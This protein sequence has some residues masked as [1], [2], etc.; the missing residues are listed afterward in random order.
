MVRAT[1][2]THTHTQA[3][4]AI[5][6]AWRRDPGLAKARRLPSGVWGKRR[7]LAQEP[8]RCILAQEPRVAGNTRANMQEV[9]HAREYAGGATWNAREASA[10]WLCCDALREASGTPGAVQPRADSDRRWRREVIPGIGCNRRHRMYSNRR[11]L[12]PACEC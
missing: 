11:R 5:K 1:T 3:W 4:S 8:W 12:P 7:I 10:R 9:E 6:L 2:H